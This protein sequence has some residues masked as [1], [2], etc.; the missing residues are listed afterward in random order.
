MRV[1]VGVRLLNKLTMRLIA[2]KTSFK[3]TAI[4][5]IAVCFVLLLTPASPTNAQQRYYLYFPWNDSQWTEG[6][7]GNRQYVDSVSCFISNV[8][9][10]NIDA[11]DVT[12]YASPEGSYQNNMRLSRERAAQFNCLLGN[13]IPS[14]PS[15]VKAGG[16]AWDLLR[17]RVV[18]DS[19][20]RPDLKQKILRILDD[21]TIS[22]DTRKWRLAN[23]LNQS[24]Y[25]YL[26]YAH[27]RYLRCF[28]IVVTVK[29]Q[30]SQ[31][32]VEPVLEP[33]QQ[34]EKV[35]QQE[36]VPPL[37]E[38]PE[39]V[40]EPQP[41]FQPLVENRP[42]KPVLAISTNIPY[43]ITYIPRYGVT[44]IPSFSLE[45]YPSNY[46]HWT[47]GADLEIP[48]W[49]HWEEHRFMQIQNLTLN[50]RYY[51]K[52]GNYHG[53]Y[54]LGNVN[55]ARY[56]I[57]FDAKGWEGEG[58]GVSV[59]VGYK[60][61]LYKRL[62]LDAGLAVGYFYSRYD[63]YEYGFDAT[64]RYYYDY[65]GVP[66]DFVKRNHVLNWFGPTRVWISIGVE[67]FGRKTDK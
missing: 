25:R 63:P 57:G 43:D 48:M 42:K 34:Q 61:T 33:A 65:V 47:V 51:F 55:A 2:N 30:E 19:K 67:L 26:L 6:Y 41:Q 39:P 36:L 31:T 3:H 40:K 50:T 38:E 56:G 54:L 52:R 5:F 9:A 13:Q 1:Y 22:D 14:V 29:E 60:L 44:S 16:E 53:L 11:M 12:A 37:I 20:I 10:D 59:G 21:T 24:D 7:F 4:F 35:L 58:L 15:N 23:Q 18:I 32:S 46:G 28:E 27:Y 8:G 17:K 45:Y 49:R 64:Q 62:F 66:E